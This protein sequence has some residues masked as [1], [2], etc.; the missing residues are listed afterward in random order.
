MG[1]DGMGGDSYGR[2]DAVLRNQLDQYH[3]DV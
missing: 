1:D 2:S 3:S